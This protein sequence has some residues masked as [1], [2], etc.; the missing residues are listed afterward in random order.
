VSP[1]RRLLVVSELPPPYGGLS[2]HTERLCATARRRGWDVTVVSPPH[3]RGAPDERFRALRVL[4]VQLRHLAR[5]F[6][7]PA[8]VVH[9]HVSTYA[10][11][12]GASRTALALQVALLLV[13]RARRAPWILSCGNG[14]LPGFLERTS[15]RL[16]A[17]Y[18]ALYGGVC[19]GIAK[20]EP[21]LRAF[22]DLGIAQRRVIGTFLDP[23][24]P[25]T[26]R[27]LAPAIEA[28][29]AAHPRAVVT[30][31]F[32]FEPLYHVDAVVRAVGALRAAGD[33]KIGLVVLATE[34][35][36]EVGKPAYDA[37]LRETGLEPHVLLL[38][39]VDHALEVIARGSVFVRATDFDG[40][41]N[42]VK[43]AMMVGVPVLATDL[44]NRPPGIELIPRGLDGL[45]ERIAALL[46]RPDAAALARNRAFVRE[47]IARNADAIF[48]LYE[49]ALR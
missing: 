46:D 20:N 11:G 43:E 47:D 15:P 18:R 22:A 19:A 10:I 39:D 9:D 4:A 5:V 42:T 37:A 27:P 6:S 35:E 36:D 24:A 31:G 3:Y 33:A 23:V 26:G 25:A 28:F 21:I 41:A 29:L 30:A 38:R 40:D 34:A 2:V 8:D 16:R 44:P 48:G 7:T 1:A 17:L 49:E 13:L 12:A 45:A 14:L 32:R